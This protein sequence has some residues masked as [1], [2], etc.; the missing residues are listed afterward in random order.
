MHPLLG[1]I[2]LRERDGNLLGSVVA[3][4]EENDYIAFLNSAIAVCVYERL[5]EF[6]G[7]LMLFGVAVVA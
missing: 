2:L 6:I 7:V 5:H 4:V 1:H 3:I